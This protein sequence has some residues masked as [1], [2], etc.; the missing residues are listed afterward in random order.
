MPVDAADGNA[1]DGQTLATQKKP[2]KRP[3]RRKK[4]VP[5]SKDVDAAS[6]ETPREAVTV[7]QTVL[8][9]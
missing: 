8:E 3:R 6:S 4:P 5:K 9:I 1:E 2:Q 7:T